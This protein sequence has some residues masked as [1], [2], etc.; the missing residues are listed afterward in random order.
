MCS[1][2]LAGQLEL[3]LC[4][5]SLI[6]T[7]FYKSCG[8]N[9]KIKLSVKA[10]IISAQA[11]FTKFLYF[12]DVLLRELSL[13]HSDNLSKALQSPKLSTSEG[14]QIAAMTVKTLL[15]LRTC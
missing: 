3:I 9:Q 6:T 10:R 13:K 5:Q 4:S 11:Q 15:L 12:F 8:K 7:L 1:A 14:Q 2:P